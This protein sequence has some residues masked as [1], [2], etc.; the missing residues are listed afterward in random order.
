MTR[1]LR[2]ILR[3]EVAIIR[4]GLSH[5]LVVQWTKLILLHITIIISMVLV[6]IGRGA[7]GLAH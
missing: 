4:H 1:E 3:E 6:L 7:R 2:I 5:K